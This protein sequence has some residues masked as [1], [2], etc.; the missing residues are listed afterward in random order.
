MID[1]TVVDGYQTA[2]GHAVNVIAA[3]LARENAQLRARIDELEAQIEA[4]KPLSVMIGAYR[5]NMRTGAVTD[6]NDRIF[7]CNLTGTERRMLDVIAEY[8]G[9]PA[10]YIAIIRRVWPDM[11]RAA[12]PDEQNHIIRVNLRRLRE[13]IDRYAEHIVTVKGVGLALRRP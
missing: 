3:D 10:P 1:T 4:T 5:V 2:N 11:L 8:Q 9:Q 13:K 12:R 6:E 7:F